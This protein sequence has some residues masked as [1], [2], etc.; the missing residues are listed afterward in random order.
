L[1]TLSFSI[2][3]AEEA[4]TYGFEMPIQQSN[5][6]G[7]FSLANISDALQGLSS[8]SVTAAAAKKDLANK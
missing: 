4:K 7:G 1:W 6:W 8:A 2:T 5:V 3:T